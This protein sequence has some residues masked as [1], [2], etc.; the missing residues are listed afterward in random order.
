M[1]K[2]VQVFLAHASEDKQ[3]VRQLYK[4]L[5]AKGFKPWL[6]ELDILPGQKWQTAIPQAIR[7]S[8]V[9]L[10]C[11]SKTSVAKQGYVQKE[12]RLAL[13]SYAERPPDKIFFIPVKLD[14]C[15][16]PRLQLP[17][18]GIDIADFQW[19]ELSR[20]EGF[21]RLVRAIESVIDVYHPPGTEQHRQL[22]FTP[23]KF[24]INPKY[25]TMAR[26]RNLADVLV[27][28]RGTKASGQVYLIPSGAA[29]K[30]LGHTEILRSSE[31]ALARKRAATQAFIDQYRDQEIEGKSFRMRIRAGE[32]VA[33]Y[34]RVYDRFLSEYAS[35]LVEKEGSV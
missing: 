9:F 33:V 4:K 26:W 6:D 31:Q 23:C 1:A 24:E 29:P 25:A 13:A 18:V 7:E 28:L 35:Q 2:A 14:D 3:H 8:D 19:V 27:D 11:L 15:Q 30:S 20:E 21:E 34:A 32:C 22:P 10:G 16:I 12:F 17:E 5:Q